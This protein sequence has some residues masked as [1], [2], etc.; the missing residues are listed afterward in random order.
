MPYYGEVPLQPPQ[1]KQ[2][3][4]PLPKVQVKK[5]LRTAGGEVWEDPTLA[6]WSK[7]ASILFIYFLLFYFFDQSSFRFF[8]LLF[9]C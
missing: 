3:E 2:E 4:K 7:G 6:E 5:I 8:P 1:A 9:F